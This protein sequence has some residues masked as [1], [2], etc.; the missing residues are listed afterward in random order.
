MKIAE[1]LYSKGFISY[2]RT[3]TNI[4]PKEIDLK[5]LVQMQTADRN[6]GEFASRILNSTSGPTPRQGKKT[7]KAHPP[8]HPTKY[9]SELTGNDKKVYE[10][11]V[12]HFLACCQKD[13][14]GEETVV[15]IDIN[16]E[17][18]TAK[19]LII[20]ERNYLEVYPYEN[21]ASKEIHN[22]TLNETFTPTVLK[23]VSFQTIIFEIGNFSVKSLIFFK[24]RL[25]EKQRHR[26]C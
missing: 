7:D 17:K 20:L 25:L 26:A 14:V 2:P 9:T 5:R 3:E 23:L 8:I 22:Y 21:W 19:G 11:V 10:F 16:G 12:R 6:W 15:N 13:A 18:F 1:K 4:F 24:F